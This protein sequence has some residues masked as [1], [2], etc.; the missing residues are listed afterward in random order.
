MDITSVCLFQREKEDKENPT[1]IYLG[2]EVFEKSEEERANKEYHDSMRDIYSLEQ[3]DRVKLF[4]LNPCRNVFYLKAAMNTS[5]S[6]L[7][8][9]FRH[10]QRINY[11]ASSRC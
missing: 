1:K 8:K 11:Q 4:P 7:E 5:S 9:C 10:S 3:H 2:Y 6:T